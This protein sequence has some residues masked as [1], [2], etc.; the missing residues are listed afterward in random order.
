[1][2]ESNSNAAPVVKG[3][4]KSNDPA[5][6][7]VDKL[8]RRGNKLFAKIK[9]LDSGFLNELKNGRF[10]KVSISLYPD[11]LLRHIGFLGGA[12]PAVKDL[13]PASFSEDKDVLENE[14]SDYT[15]ENDFELIETSKIKEDNDKLKSEINE[16]KQRLGQMNNYKINE[17]I[18]NFAESIASQ[19]TNKQM[20]TQ[21]SEFIKELL[22]LNINN[23]AKMDGQ[24]FTEYFN[25]SDYFENE[26]IQAIKS[27]IESF[28][29]LFKNQNLF[30]NF[31]SKEVKVSAIPFTDINTDG[32]D[33]ERYLLHNKALELQ[34][35]SG[36]SYEEA[37]LEAYENN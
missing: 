32:N 26:N 28:V 29:K 5:L 36:N 15:S 20:Q 16:L 1:L 24:D 3:H 12:S 27:K 35:K 9:D 18:A 34:Q 22:K 17:D 30:T 10:K 25:Y 4:P 31:S 33:V 13:E 2:S 14:F 6:G 21:V 23:P 8:T 7:W 11:N 37:L 19:F